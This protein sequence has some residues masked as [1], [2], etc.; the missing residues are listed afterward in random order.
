MALCIVVG[1]LLA[2]QTGAG[3]LSGCPFTDF[4]RILNCIRWTAAV[5]YENLPL[6]VF[7]MAFGI[8]VQTLP[9][10]SLVR[11]ALY[12]RWLLNIMCSSV[13]ILIDQFFPYFSLFRTCC[14]VGVVELL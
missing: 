8:V 10:H 1:E 14:S 12:S 2:A 7:I 9:V 13:T 5:H 11:N 4:L 3:N 6:K